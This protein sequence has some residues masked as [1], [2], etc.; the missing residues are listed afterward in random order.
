MSM[1]SLQ[2]DCGEPITG[3]VAAFVIA[4]A[5]QAALSQHKAYWLRLATE[6]ITTNIARHGYRGSGPLRLA[7]QV[8]A[9]RVWVRIEDEAPAFDPR[10]HDPRPHL[11][12]DPA[13]RDE[14]GFGLLLALHKLDGFAYERASGMNTNTLIM[15]R[16]TDT[17]EAEG[18]SDDHIDCLGHR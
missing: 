2:L 13:L 5:S 9:D 17:T 10:T 11:E 6:E 12:T 3:D 8:E 7:G 4:L 15:C 16:D 1:R 14:G 18:V